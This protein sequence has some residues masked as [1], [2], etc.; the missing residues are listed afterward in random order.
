M[1]G[2]HPLSV[3]MIDNDN[4]ERSNVLVQWLSR[5]YIMAK[6]KELDLKSIPV[7]PEE[8][9]VLIKEGK[10]E[11]VV[12][13]TQVNAVPGLLRR[14]ADYVGT[15]KDV[16]LVMIDTRK[17]ELELPFEAHSK[18]R[19]L[20]KGSIKLLV[21][22]SKSDVLP[23]MRL[24][25]EQGSFGSAYNEEGFRNFCVEDLSDLLRSNVEYVLDTECFSA[26]DAKEISDNRK[27]ICTD[28]IS[29]LN[30]K[31]PYWANYGLTVTYGSMVID[32]NRYEELEKLERDKALD[33]RQ[34]DIEYAEASGVSENRVRME[35]IA[36]KERSSIAFNEYLSRLNLEVAKWEKD[37]EAAHRKK[38]RE[39]DYGEDEQTKAMESQNR[40]EM[41]AVYHRRELARIKDD[42]DLDEA[43]KQ[44]KLKEVQLRLSELDL[45]IRKKTF[46]Q[47]E[48]EERARYEREKARL[49]DEQDRAIRGKQA[50]AEVLRQMSQRD[51][52]LEAKKVEYAHDERK[53]EINADV[54]KAKIEK[55][56]TVAEAKGDAKA[57]EA[58]LRGYRE[59]TESAHERSMDNM[60]ATRRI[61]EAANGGQSEPRGFYCPACGAR[62]D[63]RARFCGSCGAKIRGDG[64]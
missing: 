40:L 60:D 48:Y 33:A 41:L 16:Q 64:E 55:D 24:L 37:Q 34:R 44:V 56:W 32:T 5:D 39:I 62:N 43:E 6:W 15:K 58:E 7:G 14:F 30:S 36:N 13:E 42:E 4:G 45:E 46:D 25:K 35:D 47:G 51:D 23:A 27:A 18:D 52:D 38:L 28:A 54:E 12:T 26:Y 61:V 63:A 22:V 2:L 49:D 20:I 31:T 17:H 3:T 59:A 57:A 21:N 10:V 1:N 8:Y 11:E 50:E 29:A 19:S 9:C 53:A